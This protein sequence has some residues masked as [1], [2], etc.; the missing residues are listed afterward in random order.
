MFFDSDDS[1]SGYRI[2]KVTIDSS[3]HTQSAD[4]NFYKYFRNDTLYSMTRTVHPDDVGFFKDSVS[5]LEG[6]EIR[7]CI[8]RMKNMQGEYRW[9]I[10]KMSLNVQMLARGIRLTDIVVK[11]AVGLERSTTGL[12][13]IIERF[14]FL[15]SVQESIIFEYSSQTS[16]FYIYSFDYNANTVFY[17]ED[18]D[19]FRFH[20]LSENFISESSR[21]TFESFCESVKGGISRFSFEMETSVLTNGDQTSLQ[22]FSGF[23]ETDSDENFIVLGLISEKKTLSDALSAGN[24]AYEA[25]L[26]SL[27]RLFSK[28]NITGYAE[29]RIESGEQKTVTVAIIDIDNFKYINDTYGHLFGDDIICTAAAVIKKETG[30]KGAAGR[31]GGDEFMIVLDNVSDEIEL[32][33]ILRAIRSNIEMKCAEKKEGL[34]VT[35]SMGTACFPDDAQSYQQLFR[36]ADKAL[37]IAK[38]KGKDR[39]VIYNREKH[40]AV[41]DEDTT[42]INTALSV[43]ENA[44]K[45]EVV[46]RI[47][48]GLTVTGTV[49]AEQAVQT[50]ISLFELDR[51]RLYTGFELSLRYSFPQSDENENAGYVF[52]DGYLNNFT[53]SGVFVTDNTDALEGRNTEA[54]S[55]L[56]KD[57]VQASVQCVCR[58]NDSVRGMISFELTSHFKKWPQM[59]VSFMSILSRILFEIIK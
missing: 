30:N 9:M 28:K 54:F 56:K 18:F 24:P 23:T 21:E 41:E 36:T 55:C 17:N 37:Y 51:I 52:S 32:R 57:G 2:G 44:D 58:E 7:H 31:I 16:R 43:K 33:S 42:A 45:T 38:E 5:S 39:Y 26:D 12:E 53:E 22:Q 48:S 3:F 6:D 13:N 14:R 50:M 34:K 10:M 25:N 47:I 29:S 40:G 59:D 1:S 20:M 11:D 49:T 19:Y 27:T 46:S 15:L 8:I 35:C 4:E